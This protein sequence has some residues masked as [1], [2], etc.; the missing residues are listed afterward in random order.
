MALKIGIVGLPNVG[1]STL[2]QAL[3]RISVPIAPYPFTTIE[4]HVGVVAV[5][6]ERLEKLRELVKP[7]KTIPATIEFV[8]IA[9]LVKGAAE[10]AG[11]GNQFLSYIYS[12]D[13]ILFLLRAFRDSEIP[14]SV[15]TSEG[16]PAPDEELAILRDELHK[17]DQEVLERNPATQRLSAKPALIVCNV[18]GENIAAWSGCEMELDCKLELEMSEMKAE[19]LRELGVVSKLPLLIQRAYEVL[20][21]IT[22][23]TIKGGKELHA[24]PIRS[25][26]AAPGAGGAVHSDFQEKF[27]RAEV[28]SWQKL[29]EAG[30]WTR[31]RELGW[32]R[33][34]GR[35]YVV[36]DG[37]VIEFKI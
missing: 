19:E 30:S 16:K 1:K 7:E 32:L 4:P 15:E 14:S 5:P 26:V 6:D 13:A 28:I 31:A 29:I 10:G 2:F 27:I 34:E 9:G 24:W 25:G 11:L 33:I 12:V 20:R 8:D 18:R 3:T 21:L 35:E 23:Y 22:F 17:K 36:Q 37:D